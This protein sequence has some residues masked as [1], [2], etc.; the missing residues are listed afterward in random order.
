LEVAFF[1]LW[2]LFGLLLCSFAFLQAMI[3]YAPRIAGFCGGDVSL[4]NLF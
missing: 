2:P 4:G 1:G 3:D